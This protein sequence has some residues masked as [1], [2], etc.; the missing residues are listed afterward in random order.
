MYSCVPNRPTG[1]YK[2]TGY[3]IELFGYYIKN[4]FLFNIFFWKIHQ[5]N[6][7][8]CAFIKDRNNFE[9]KIMKCNIFHRSI[10]VNFK[11]LISEFNYTLFPSVWIQILGIYSII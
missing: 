9:L 5:K 11:S 1:P 10:T 4:Y 2:R 6:L 8:T 7:S 3:Y